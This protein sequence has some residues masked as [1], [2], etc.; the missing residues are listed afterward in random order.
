MKKFLKDPLVILLYRHLAAFLSVGL[1]TLILVPFES[2]F[3]IQT[4]AL[5][6][7]LVVMISTVFWGLTAG[8]LSGFLAFLTFNFFF[9]PAILYL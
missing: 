7:L 1:I 6:Y 8:V 9:I 5:I 4:I 2:F 3:A